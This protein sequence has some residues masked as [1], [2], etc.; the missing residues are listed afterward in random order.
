MGYPLGIRNYDD[1]SGSPFY[2][3]PEEDDFDGRLM[4]C[5]VIR[6]PFDNFMAQ[7]KEHGCKFYKDMALDIIRMAEEVSY[8]GDDLQDLVKEMLN[9]IKDATP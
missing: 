5:R 6:A 7:Y 3:E 1:C 2:N 4:L 9:D 8:E